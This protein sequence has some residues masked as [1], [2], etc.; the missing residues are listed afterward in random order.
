MATCTDDGTA[1]R[2]TLGG[3]PV[4]ASVAEELADAVAE[5]VGRGRAGA[6]VE[7]HGTSLGRS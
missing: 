4:L 2:V 5:V 1:V 6:A 3:D 7:A